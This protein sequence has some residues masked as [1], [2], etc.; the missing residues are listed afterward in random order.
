M[1]LA[2]KAH[3]VYEVTLLLDLSVRSEGGPAYF[4]RS[5]ED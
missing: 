1:L 4:K 5:R 2:V 3:T